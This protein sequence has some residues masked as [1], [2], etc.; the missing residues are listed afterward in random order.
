MM[1]VS[2]DTME[3]PVTTAYSTAPNAAAAM[4]PMAY[5]ISSK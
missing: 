1:L 2:A 5:S 4:V 3:S